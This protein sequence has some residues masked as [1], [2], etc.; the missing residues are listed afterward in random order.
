[1]KEKYCLE[2]THKDGSSSTIYPNNLKQQGLLEE[3]LS[4]MG[5]EVKAYVFIYK[6]KNGRKIFKV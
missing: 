5:L 2:V 3:V 4:G 6:V 1:M